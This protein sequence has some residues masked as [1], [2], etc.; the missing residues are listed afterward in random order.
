MRESIMNKIS[1]FF[2]WVALLPG[3]WY[4]RMGVDTRQLALILRYKLIM[5]DRRPNTF[6]QT[7]SNKNKTG[8]SR[9][10]YGTMVIAL[11]MGL[12]NLIAFAMG[13]DEL[14]N[15][16]IY[17]S[18]FLFLLS[19]TLISDFT[20]VLIDVRDTMIL[21]PKPVNDRTFLMGRILH[22]MVHLF[23]IIVPMLLPALVFLFLEYAWQVALL[24]LLLALLACLLAIFFINAV[25]LLIIRFT[26]PEK[27]KSF[28]AWFQI[29][30]MVLIYGAYQVL[31]RAGTMEA[32]QSFSVSDYSMAAIFPPYWFAAA[33]VDGAGLN[34]SS[35]WWWFLWSLGSSIG[36]VWVVVRFL[37]PSFNQKLAMLN[38]GDSGKPPGASLERAVASAGDRRFQQGY[39]ASMAALLTTSSIERA[40]FLFTWKWALRNRGFRMRVYPA[41]GY[42]VVWFAVSLYRNIF[43]LSDGDIAATTGGPTVGILGLIYLSCFIFISAIQQISQADEYKASWIFYSTPVSAPGPILLGTIK[44]LL[45]Q[46]FLP[47]AA[48]L[49]VLGISWQGWQ[50]IPN[51]LLGFCN[52]VLISGLLVLLNYKKLPASLPA[53][54][55]AATGNFLRGLSLLLFNGGFGLVHYFIYSFPVVVLISIA[56]S[57]LCVWL[58][59]RRIARVGWSEVSD[60]SLTAF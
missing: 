53:N 31:P 38:E 44:A 14:T 11:L 32:V 41:I 50:S 39:A 2:Y 18:L 55:A 57:A 35:A 10:T 27:F 51:L 58:I 43:H 49:L 52:Q 34:G 9:A 59:Y 15:F 26:T 13:A 23:R 19:S 28:I 24:F 7:Q 16:T 29:G 45:T 37:A 20:A 47:L 54:K 17:F 30:F 6:Q 25:Y 48:V 4:R 1:A 40:G 3:F 60:T 42:I 46:F 5:D 21:L 12:L 33:L 36:S 8:I 56:L 22:I